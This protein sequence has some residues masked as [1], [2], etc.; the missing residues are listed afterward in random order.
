MKQA[1]DRGRFCFEYAGVLYKS[2]SACVKAITG[3]NWNG[4]LFFGLTTRR[5]GA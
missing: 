4:K 1:S 5:T 2:L 3:A